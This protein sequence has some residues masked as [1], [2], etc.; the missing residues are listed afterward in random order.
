M[1]L[2]VQLERVPPRPC[3]NPTSN[4]ETR[5]RVL[6]DVAEI[7]VWRDPEC[8]AA[9]WL[10]DNGKAERGDVLHTYRGDTPCMRGSVGWFADRRVVEDD[11]GPRFVKW[12]PNPFALL[13]GDSEK[14]A[15]DDEAA[16]P[17]AA[18]P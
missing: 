8:S 5:Y 3:S 16:T 14:T 13:R 7:G 18:D 15:T 11:S 1:I 9:R 6:F 12:R 2:R 4:T 17:V 10:I